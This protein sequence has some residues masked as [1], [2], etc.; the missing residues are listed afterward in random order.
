M[1]KY[2]TVFAISWQNEFTYRL[3]FILWRLRNVV[4]FLMTYFL[5]LGV[6]SSIPAAFGY[7]R[8]QMLAYVF[9]V[10]IVQ[11]IVLSSPSSDN[12][13]GEIANGDLSNYLVKPVNYL[14]Y[15]FIRDLSS[16]LLNLVF[17]VFEITALWLIFRP[18]V[19]LPLSFSAAAG[20]IISCVLAVA[21][22]FFLS[23]GAR[24]TAFWMPESTWGF[25]FVLIIFMEVLAGGI[26]PLDILPKWIFNLLQFTPFPYLIYF[27]IAIFVGKISGLEMLRVLA[28]AVFISGGTFLAARFIWQKG[29]R[30]YGA[31]GR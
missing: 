18:A 4:R 15:W 17:A 9:M 7:S 12:I 25:A 27:P 26:F 8:S 13:G 6:F 5:W 20:F 14:R 24:F 23:A 21:I 10:L 19:Q 3:N 31:E 11:S 28:Q 16:K 30:I 2:L 22:N 29:L 1:Q